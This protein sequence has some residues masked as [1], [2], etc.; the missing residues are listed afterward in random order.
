MANPVSALLKQCSVGFL[1]WQK[2]V[3]TAGGL[4][5]VLSPIDLLPDVLPVLGWG[6]D[7]FLIYVLFRVWCSPT[8]PNS[9]SGGS[10]GGCIQLAPDPV[11]SGGGR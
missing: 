4:L 10:S 6:D 2:A 8:L 5:Y 11:A 1:P 9:G 7:V 3:I